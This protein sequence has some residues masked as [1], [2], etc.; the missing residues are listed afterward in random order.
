MQGDLHARR[1]EAA[2]LTKGTSTSTI[3]QLVLGTVV[4]TIERDAAVLDFGAGTGAL[5]K[6]L[7]AAGFHRITAADILPRPDG[8][9]DLSWIQRDL[10]EPLPV[11]DGQYD[12]IVS[13]EVLEHLENPRAVF[14]EFSRLLRSGG[15]LMVTT[16]NQESVRSLLSLLVRGH[17]VD[18]LDSSYPAH[19]SAVLRMD[20]SRMCLE[21]GFETPHF[22]YTDVGGLPAAPHIT[23]QQVSAGFLRGRRFSDTLAM[24]ARKR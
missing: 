17:H 5:V 14:R 12:A 10:N 15:H 4:R 2:R 21:N 16:P 7:R 3:C 11:S 13:T 1:I 8:L 19:I 24:H 18:F 6:M 22:F 20:L 9:D 23:W